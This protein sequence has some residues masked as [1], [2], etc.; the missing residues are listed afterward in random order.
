[1]PR[2]RVYRWLVI[3][4][5]IAANQP[6]RAQERL[7]VTSPDGRNE[8]TVRDARREDIPSPHSIPNALANT[9]RY[10]DFAA[11]NHLGGVLVEG[12]NVRWDG[13]WI[14]NRNGAGIAEICADGP[15]AN[16]LTNPLPVAI[17]S[18]AVNSTTHLRIALA[19]GGGQAIRIRPTR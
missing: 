18:K 19:P 5:A 9:R 14:A 11:A 16:W 13:D 3:A 7:R 1:M 6:L 8:V 4:G 15:S 10:I 17:S 12:W 2:L